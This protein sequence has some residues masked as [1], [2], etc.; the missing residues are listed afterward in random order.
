MSIVKYI[1]RE[2]GRTFNIGQALKDGW[3]LEWSGEAALIGLKLKDREKPEHTEEILRTD[4]FAGTFR[5]FFKS[6]GWQCFDHCIEQF[7][8]VIHTPFIQVGC[9]YHATWQS[10]KAMRFVLKEVKGDKARLIT[11]NSK[12]DF[13]TNVSA[14][15]FIN[16]P[17]NKDKAKRL[18]QEK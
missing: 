6:G 2:G 16:T 1:D 10:N 4:W 13:W 11:R 15:I 8:R 14:L 3:G 7:E 17:Y 18:A 12:K 5:V 9:N